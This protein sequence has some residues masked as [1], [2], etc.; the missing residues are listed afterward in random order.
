VLGICSVYAI[1]AF[2]EVSAFSIISKNNG[3]CYI[4]ETKKERKK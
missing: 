1:Q 2:S 3:R 4:R